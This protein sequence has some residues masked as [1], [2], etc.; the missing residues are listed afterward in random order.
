MAQPAE[1]S[2]G[3][4]VSLGAFCLM[5]VGTNHHDQFSGKACQLGQKFNFFDGKRR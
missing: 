4:G 2:A 1:E 5:T 3:L